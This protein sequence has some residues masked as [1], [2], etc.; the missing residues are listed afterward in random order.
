[1]SWPSM[2]GGLLQLSADTHTTPITPVFVWQVGEE[3]ETRDAHYT[4][5]QVWLGVPWREG[6][7]DVTRAMCF[8]TCLC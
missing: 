7:E 8:I 6:K 1:M 3:L 5:R 4:Y 2:L